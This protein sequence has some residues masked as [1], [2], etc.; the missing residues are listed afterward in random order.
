[1]KSSIVSTPV[2]SAKGSKGNVNSKFL[3]KAVGNKKVKDT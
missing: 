3:R 2:V 1:M